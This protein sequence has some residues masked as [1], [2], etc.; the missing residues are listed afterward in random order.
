MG[1]CG[2]LACFA[3]T[4]TYGL[5]LI[6]LFSAGFFELS[7]S[8]MAQTV[9]QIEAPAPVRGRVLGVF[10]MASLGCRAFAGITVGLIGALLGVH[11]SLALA[12]GA[13]LSIVSILLFVNRTGEE[14]A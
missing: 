14:R 9:V 3:L 5:A 12:A 2:A 7:F 13:L 8:S 11:F 6:C 1:W 4:R 10:A